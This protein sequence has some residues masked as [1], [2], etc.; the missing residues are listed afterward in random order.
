M[1]IKHVESVL[2]GGCSVVVRFGVEQRDQHSISN[3]RLI[4]A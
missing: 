4:E 3:S 2:V 1:R